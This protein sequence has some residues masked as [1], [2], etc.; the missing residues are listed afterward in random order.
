M[1]PPPPPS[2]V[3][4]PPAS[5]SPS[6]L[7]QQTA[8]GSPSKD[9]AAGNTATTEAPPPATSGVKE[10]TDQMEQSST[11][12]SDYG[13]EN[14]FPPPPPPPHSSSSASASALPAAS[15][16]TIIASMSV[17]TSTTTSSSTTTTI[18][19]GHN[20][21]NDNDNKN[22]SAMT[23]TTSSTTA[24]TTSVVATSLI[25]SDSMDAQQHAP[26]AA[27]AVPSSG[28]NPTQGRSGGQRG[29]MHKAS[30]ASLGA[31]L[32]LQQQQQR[33]Q[34][35]MAEEKAKRHDLVLERKLQEMTRFID[36]RHYLDDDVVQLL[37]QMCKDFLTETLKGG[38][39]LAKHRG[40]KRLEVKDV[41]GFTERKYPVRVPGFRERDAPV[42]PVE[43]IA[44]SKLVNPSM[45]HRQRMALIRRFQ[46]QALKKTAASSNPN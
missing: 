21:N 20:N 3:S 11:S 12:N 45:Q 1:D 24:T 25:G 28:G 37:A 29:L 35:D 14:M 31:Q 7:Q 2:S 41:K 40:S 9:N 38:A 22:N 23:S 36:H 30:S 6:Q 34:I 39:R 32:A 44:A 10:S 43:R 19:A 17:S 5:L 18:T 16:S 46:N 13:S 8:Q 42:Q 15:S 4:N 33:K 26:R 27:F